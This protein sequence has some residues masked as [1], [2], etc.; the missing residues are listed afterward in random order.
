MCVYRE[1]VARQVSQTDRQQEQADKLAGEWRA[2]WRG[3]LKQQAATAAVVGQIYRCE[4]SFFLPSTARSIKKQFSVMCSLGFLLALCRLGLSLFTLYTLFI[5]LYNTL[6][7]RGDEETAGMKKKKEEEERKKRR[8]KQQKEE[9]GEEEEDLT[10]IEEAMVSAKDQLD[11]GGA[12]LRKLRERAAAAV[13]A[14]GMGQ[15]QT[16]KA[17][18]QKDV[19]QKFDPPISSIKLRTSRR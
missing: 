3:K 4:H 11:D 2:F 13:A 5:G 6:L 14:A 8:E 18:H 16:I 12:A 19:H 17:G 15:H 10:K 7:M 9:A 1:K